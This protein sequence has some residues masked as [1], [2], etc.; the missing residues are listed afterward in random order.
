MKS[1]RVV[2]RTDASLSVGSGHLMR[3]L[4]L[5][6]HLCSSRMEVTFACY[7]T[8]DG[9]AAQILDNRYR[10]IRLDDPQPGTLPGGNADLLIVDHYGL[11]RSWHQVMRTFARHI[12]V[13][14][15]LADRPLDCDLLLNQNIHADPTAYRHLLPEGCITLLGTRYSLLRPEFYQ[16]APH[17]QA[18][19]SL[20]RL[21]LCFGGSDPCHLTETAM[22]EM[23]DSP[24]MIDVVIGAD[25]KRY[26]AI[27]S[28]CDANQDRWT[29]HIQTDA[30]ATLMALADLAIGAGG[31]SHWERCLLGLP[32]LVVTVADNQ[33]ES[34]RLLHE[35]RAC[36]WL[37]DADD[38]P[39]GTIR[40]A[41]EKLT[42]EPQHLQQMSRIA[43]EVVPQNGGTQ[44][45][46]KTI[47]SMLAADNI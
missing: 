42:H 26:S 21:L 46:V 17:T 11:D 12:M 40:H 4:T 28:L 39:A 6:D 3:C 8:A 34:T 47:H 20:K 7:D 13:I 45:V 25:N 33:I 31:S 22:K 14:D 32:A 35:Q 41:V 5:A 44:K 24:M 27:K 38:L 1:V 37:G 18:R 36:W 29:L 2:I 16:L 23:V 19:C 15:D 30:M 43:S 10:M 9:S